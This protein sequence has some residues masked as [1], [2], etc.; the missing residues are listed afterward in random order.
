MAAGLKDKLRIDRQLLQWMQQRQDAALP[1]ADGAPAAA[2]AA[3][4]F[5]VM[6]AS[7]PH[8][9]GMKRQQQVRR[10]AIALSLTDDCKDLDQFVV[11][12]HLVQLR[13]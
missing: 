2:A 4:R 12:K 13:W 5:E 10:R 9:P 3:A 11:A 6:D 7:L 8:E 1:R